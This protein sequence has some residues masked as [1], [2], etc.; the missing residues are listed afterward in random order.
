MFT[1]KYFQTD[2]IYP[3]RFAKEKIMKQLKNKKNMID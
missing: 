1:I 2:G 3:S